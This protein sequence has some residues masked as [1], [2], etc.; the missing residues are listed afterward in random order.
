LIGGSHCFE[1]GC[2]FRAVQGTVE[3]LALGDGC[4]SGAQKFGGDKGVTVNLPKVDGRWLGLAARE[5][6]S[7]VSRGRN[8]SSVLW[9]PFGFHFFLRATHVVFDQATAKSSC[10]Y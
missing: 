7:Q 9:V 10:S 5:T 8:S 6:P 3:L 4:R 1:C 2:I